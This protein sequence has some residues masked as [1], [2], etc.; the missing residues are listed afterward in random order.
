MARSIRLGDSPK[1]G[2]AV[3]DF[4]K[5]KFHVSYNFLTD[6]K[7]AKYNQLKTG[8][9]ETFQEVF[10]F[11]VH[12]C[13]HVINQ[14]VID[15]MKGAYGEYGGYGFKPRSKYTE[16]LYKLQG[17]EIDENAM[18][19][20]G[21]SIEELSKLLQQ[22]SKGS[23]SWKVPDIFKKDGETVILYDVAS[24]DKVV[25]VDSR[26]DVQQ[27]NKLENIIGRM[28]MGGGGEF[29]FRGYPFKYGAP[30][31]T[32][33][34]GSLIIRHKKWI[35]EA[36]DAAKRQEYI[37]R[38]SS[39]VVI[40]EPKPPRPKSKRTGASYP[41]QTP[42]EKNAEAL[43]KFRYKIRQKSLGSVKNVRNFP[44]K[45]KPMESPPLDYDVYHKHKPKK[46]RWKSGK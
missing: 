11:F 37:S 28:R 45:D 30:I 3:E 34:Y 15:V 6:A 24:A 14:T 1:F 19:K 16:F 36:W 43:R 17:I 29:N 39:E 27:P 7:A 23:V 21:K 46:A 35:K 9:I 31:E 10:R 8:G 26:A 25:H 22:R 18:K 4:L 2:K 5:M 41:K 12:N 33:V 40:N 13:M 32:A 42:E 38:K 44:P 20:S